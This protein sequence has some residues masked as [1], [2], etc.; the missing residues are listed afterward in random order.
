MRHERGRARPRSA[1]GIAPLLRRLQTLPPGVIR[2][3]RAALVYFG[4]SAVNAVLPLLLLPLLTTHLTPADYGTVALFQAI[5]LLASVLTHCGMASTVMRS[6]TVGPEGERRDY[7]ASALVVI[8]V[9]ASAATLA[10]WPLGLMLGPAAGFS[11][12]WFV[13]AIA[14]GGFMSF[15]QIFPVVLQARH[16]AFAFA[17]VQIATAVLNLCLTLVLVVGLDKGWQGRSAAIAATYLVMSLVSLGVMLARRDIGL[18]RRRHVVDALKLGG[19]TLPHTLLN[20]AMTVGDRFLLSFFFSDAVVG[21][22]AAASQMASG[23]LFIGMAIH[24][25]IQPTAMRMIAAAKTEAQRRRLGKIAL[26]LTAMIVTMALVYMVLVFLFAERFI[27][28]R[29]HGFLEYFYLLG[30]A[31]ILQSV[32]FPFSYALFYYRATRLLAATGVA[33]AAVFMAV[34]L[35]GIFLFGSVGVSLGIVAARGGLLAVA[36]IW[37]IRLTSLPQRGRGMVP[38][39]QATG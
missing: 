23:L 21:I 2:S 1:K 36:V 27:N 24:G 35:V 33:L 18:P 20:T 34:A 15:N 14:T 19:S 22:Y 7:L 13:L 32:Y 26:W 4:T 31:A 3:A 17:I 28:P 38:V 8:G 5:A 12:G 6:L 11:D 30:F 16:E 37:S 25:A 39:A 9:C 29:F 10:S